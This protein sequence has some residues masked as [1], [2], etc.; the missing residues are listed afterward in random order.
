[1]WPVLVPFPWDQPICLFLA[2]SGSVD[3]RGMLD[4]ITFTF[5]QTAQALWRQSAMNSDREAGVGQLGER[6][7]QEIKMLFVSFLY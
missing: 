7:D 1:M 6:T 2:L 5:K 4:L 3:P